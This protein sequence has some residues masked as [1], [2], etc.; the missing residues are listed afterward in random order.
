MTVRR[1]CNARNLVTDTSLVRLSHW[2][3]KQY[4]VERIKG[5]C[6]FYCPHIFPTSLTIL[7]CVIGCFIFLLVYAV[8]WSLVVLIVTHIIYSFLLSSSVLPGLLC[9]MGMAT[10]LSTRLMGGLARVGEG[11]QHCRTWCAFLCD[12]K[13]YI[14]CKI[15]FSWITHSWNQ[16]WPGILKIG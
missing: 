3:Y 14:Y 4:L 12:C 10:D 6:P 5:H 7:L 15:S 8:G 9:G 11:R 16:N 1:A 2:R 13:K